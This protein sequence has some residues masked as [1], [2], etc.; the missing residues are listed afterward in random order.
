MARLED[1]PVEV[2]CS[3]IDWTRAAVMI[4][5]DTPMPASFYITSIWHL[6]R[7]PYPSSRASSVSSLRQPA[8]SIAP[9]TSPSGTTARLLPM[10]SSTAFA[11]STSSMPS[12]SEPRREA[13]DSSVRNSP[14]DSSRAS[15]ARPAKTPHPPP[16]TFP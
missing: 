10:P 1:L 12:R 5:A 8:R 16:W 4:P 6:C 9:R 15:A 7:R 11:T 14:A 3:V 13:S 2:S